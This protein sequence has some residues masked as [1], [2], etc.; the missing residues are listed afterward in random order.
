MFG[1]MDAIEALRELSGN[2]DQ[3]VVAARASERVDIQTGV[4]VR[5]ANASERDRYA[6]DTVTA[7][8]SDGGCMLLS[9]QP[10]MTGDLF[11]LEFS[12]KHVRIGS[13][14]ARCMRCRVVSEGAFEVGFKFMNP[15]DL[16]SAL[17]SQPSG[18]LVG[19]S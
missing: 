11:W 15:I 2:Q 17:V 14:F 18:E 7:D 13:L 3:A 4:V 8:I 6:H 5:P 9:P 19:Q 12:E 16:R 10:L 1:A